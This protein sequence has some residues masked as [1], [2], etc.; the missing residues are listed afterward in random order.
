MMPIP[1][2]RRGSAR[3]LAVVLA[4][5]LAFGLIPGTSMGAEEELKEA[6]QELRET[7]EKIRARG[8][9]LNALQRELNRLATE[10]TNNQAQIN[11][12]EER[13]DKLGG[14]IAILELRTDRLQDALNDR[15]REAFIEGPGAPV[16]YLLTATSA[17]EAAA[18]I[19]I[20]NEMNRRDGVLARK[21]QENSERLSRGRAEML[22]LQRARQLAIQQLEVQ[23][24]QLEQKFR[25]VRKL[26][27]ELRGHKEEV[28]EV[29]RKYR[30]FAVCP[31]GDPHALTNSFGIW[32]H[33]SK[34]RGGD[35]VHQGI[36]IMA[37]GGTPIYAPFPGTAVAVPN[38]LG[39]NAVNVYGDHGYVYNAHLSAYGQ[40]GPV[41]AGDV[42]GYV[43]AT[44]NTGANHDHF[45]WHPD[46]GDAA[47]PYPLLL[48]IC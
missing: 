26:Q 29:I 1:V 4:G 43:G 31:V 11:E 34:E 15:N 12:A 36:D 6:R 46:D 13:M 44:G 24:A 19:S 25:E 30:P 2:S 3:L 17:A 9:K 10:M 28:L 27:A 42:I 20:I 45:E 48:K 40:L 18:R 5:A 22:R 8:R 47:D 33:R 41:E 14:Q 37:P 16:L 35:H 21:V 32:V 23:E 38:K 7:R 39:G